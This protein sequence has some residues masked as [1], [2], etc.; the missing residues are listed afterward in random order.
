MDKLKAMELFVATA[1][2][3]SFSETGRRYGLSPASVSRHINDLEAALGVTLLQR[4]TRALG[5]TESG[6]TYLRDAREVLASV[7]AADIAATAQQDQIGGVLR[8]HSR[9]MFGI[10]VLAPLQT[11]FQARH[12]DLVVEL[13]LSEHPARLREDNFDIDFRIAPPRENGLVRRRLFQSRRI[14]V[15]APQY[16]SAHPAIKV[17][18][19][20]MGHDCL[21]YWKS[22]EPT[23]WRFRTPEGEQELG[24]PVRFISNNGL[25][26]LEMARAGAGIAL[27]DE[28]T[29][30]Q[31]IAAGRLVTLLG[32]IPVTNTTFDEGIFATYVKTP[33]VPAKLRLY[34]DFVAGH[35]GDAHRGELLSKS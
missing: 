25:V 22:H 6:E 29:V 17:P 12:P 14:L 9:T 20:L 5:L 26:L 33:F 4:S 34:I 1:D 18:K 31:D 30:A 3:G 21:A 24:V 8:V 2:Q 10:S 7:K 16:L 13:H 35:W 19:D 23:Y 28:Y 11:I 15:A 27:L 32:D